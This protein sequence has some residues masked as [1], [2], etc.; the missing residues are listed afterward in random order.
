MTWIDLVS[1]LYFAA[2]ES[3]SVH[4]L[5]LLEKPRP[6]LFVFT[7]LIDISAML[8]FYAH[9]PRGELLM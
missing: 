3:D 4:Y 8:F 6:Y 7:G 9:H 1:S 2:F 5:I